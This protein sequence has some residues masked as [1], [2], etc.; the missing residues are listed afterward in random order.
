MAAWWR[1]E[2]KPLTVAATGCLRAEAYW[3]SP[4]RFELVVAWTDRDAAQV[5]LDG[6][7]HAQF[8]ASMDGMRCRVLE[9][10]VGDRID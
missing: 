10:I 6:P 8:K 7:A 1:E 4:G 9:R 5:F 2:G 3:S